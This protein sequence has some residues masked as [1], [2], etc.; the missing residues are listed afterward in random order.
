MPAQLE[1]KDFFAL[2]RHLIV[3]LF[4]VPFSA[5]SDLAGVYSNSKYPRLALLSRDHFRSEVMDQFSNSTERVTILQKFD[6]GL[7]AAKSENFE[8]A[9]KTWA[10]IASN[11]KFHDSV[12]LRNNIAAVSFELM[13][14]GKRSTVYVHRKIRKTLILLPGRR[15]RFTPSDQN[16]VQ[17]TVEENQRKYLYWINS[18]TKPVSH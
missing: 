7:D 12:V 3:A 2:S 14:Q 8:L 18:Q 5:I 16:L 13:K 10:E 15:R 9:L 17:S 1:W 11:R 6:A 4:K